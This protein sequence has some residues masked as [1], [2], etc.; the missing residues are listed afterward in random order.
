MLG[1]HEGDYIT[2]LS[3][4]KMNEGAFE[5]MRLSRRV[6]SGSDAK[7]HKFNNEEVEYPYPTALHLDLDGR[8]A[9]GFER[10]TQGMG[11]LV[12]PSVLKLFGANI[13]RYGMTLLVG[14]FALFSLIQPLGKEFN[15]SDLTTAG[16]TLLLSVAV[17][18][19]VTIFDLRAK[20][21]Y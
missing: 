4:R 15:W 20:I 17:T 9:L 6:F 8:M 14:L 16:I 7:L 13:V 1:L 10:E 19:I 12:T 21:R 2:I 18:V 11:A 3:A 5:I